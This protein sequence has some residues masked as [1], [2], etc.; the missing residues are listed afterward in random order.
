MIQVAHA[1][2]VTVLSIDR[3]ERRNAVDLETITTLGDRLEE[4][5]AAGG[6]VVVVTGA[7]GNFSA[8]A[9]L[10]GVDEDVF[11]GAL[12]CTLLLLR[13]PAYVS[14]AAVEGVAL[15]VGMQ[16][17]VS[18]DLRVATADCRF[19]VP[20]AKLGLTVDH[21]T[22]RRLAAFA[23]EGPARAMLLAAEDLEGAAAHRIGLVQRIGGLDEALSWAQ[24][25]AGLAPLTIQAH[26][27][28]LER[29]AE[30]AADPEFA[31]ARRKA[32]RSD[33]LQEGLAAFRER[34]PPDFRGE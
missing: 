3:P 12:T 32:W 9:D 7:G 24:H 25:I 17:S 27:L 8:G 33:D 1:A 4:T 16:L 34:R 14:I 10:A 31:E 15:G 2:G 21:E 30:H 6:R 29:I 22:V 20:A 18:C 11:V 5:K 23:G 19:G 13:D 26:K 28:G